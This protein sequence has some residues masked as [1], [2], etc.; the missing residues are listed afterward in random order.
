MSIL[1]HN[2]LLIFTIV[3][4]AACSPTKNLAPNEKLYTGASVEVKSNDVSTKERKVLRSELQAL[5]RPKPN[6]RFLG[7]P[8]KLNIY[9]L[10]YKS[11][12][13]SF[14]GKFRDKSGEP[15]VLLSSVDLQNNIKLL[16]NNLENKGFFK[17][18]VTGDTTVKGKKGNAK[19]IAETGSQ[20][21]INMVLFDSSDNQLERAVKESA[22]KSL[23][24]KGDPYNFDVIKLERIRIDA[25]LKEKGFFYF[26]P[27]YLII[28]VDSTRGE[29]LVDIMVSV[30]A[31]TPDDARLAYI[32]DNVYIY[33]NYNLAANRL[34]TAISTAVTYEGYSIIDRKKQFK[35]K[36]FPPIMVFDSGELYNRTDHNLTLSRLINLNE[37][38]FVKNRFEPVSDS[39]KLDAYYYLTPLPRKSLRAEINAT[40]K[41][42]G[43]KGTNLQL[44]WKNRNTFRAGEQLNV[45]AYIGTELQFGGTKVDKDGN[46]KRYNTYRTGAEMNFVI[47]RFVTFGLFNLNKRSAY[48]PR[49]NLQLGYDVLNRRELYTLN[50]FRAAIGYSWKESIQKQHEFHPISINY[51][52]PINVTQEYRDSTFKYPYLERIIDSQFIIGSTYN[53]NYNDLATGLQK[54]NAF[55]FNGLVDLSGNVAGLLIKEKA[56]DGNGKRLFNAKFDQ[57]L[58]LETDLRYYRKLGLKSSWANRFILGYGNP[59]G[60]SIQLPYIKQFF[61]GGNNSIRAFRS[62]SVGPGTFYQ[63]DSTSFFADQTGDIKM[64]FNTEFRP[65]ITGPLYGAVFLDIGNIWLKNEDPSRPGANFSKDFLKQLAIGAGAGIRLDIVLFVIR[66]DVGVPLR[67]PWETPPSVINQIDFRNKDYRRE[68]IV[69]NLA[70]GYP[71]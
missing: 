32:I 9:N 63:P 28:R 8:F 70:I 3:L 55:Y 4:L 2:I 34:D 48:V 44:S 43:L 41:D 42:N 59:Y 6:T 38:K 57:Y 47:P 64:E 61:V 20:Y 46:V 29:N 68:N 65:H 12:A 1:R 14:F 39:A 50:S 7:I 25:D 56:S 60:N 21:N 35:P 18:T 31:E 62:R 54:T 30:K 71:F 40:A 13:N 53:Y 58:K 27:E 10:F 51:V 17:A 5:T 22:A 16:Q 37:F 11:K 15:P 52:Q 24:K 19:Y 69:F 45:S 36:F 49:T 33:A 26:S 67:K 23:L 66:L